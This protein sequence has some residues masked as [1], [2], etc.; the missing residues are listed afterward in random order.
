[1]A[2]SQ[3]KINT[4]GAGHFAYLEF[5]CPDLPPPGEVKVLRKVP[6]ATTHTIAALPSLTPP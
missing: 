1:M 2:S 4:S 5:T 6:S 3:L